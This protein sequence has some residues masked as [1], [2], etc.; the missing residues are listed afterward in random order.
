MNIVF[1]QYT[2]LFLS[3][4]FFGGVVDHVILAIIR[5]PITPFGL[6]ANPKRNL[7]YAAFDFI[8]AGA[9]FSVFLVLK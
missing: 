8:I 3:G 2:A 6:Q 9:F 4:F 5:S 7:I 1:W